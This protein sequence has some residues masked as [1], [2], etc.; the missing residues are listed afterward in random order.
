MARPTLAELTA[1]IEYAELNREVKKWSFEFKQKLTAKLN[2][3]NVKQTGALIDTIKTRAVYRDGMADHVSV[4]YRYYGIFAEKGVGKGIN[5][6]NVASNGA[7][8]SRK[9]KPWLSTT[10]DE[11]IPVLAEAIVRAYGEISLNSVHF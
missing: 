7:L 2:A 3:L 11:E 10:L 6:E 5:I 4:K 9:P 8:Y 1:P